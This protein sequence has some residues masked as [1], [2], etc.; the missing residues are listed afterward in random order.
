MKD[1][2]LNFDFASLYPNVVK[3]YDNILTIRRKN[4]IRRL[5]N[6]R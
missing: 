5:F 3:T 2:I 1:K 4:K 6:E